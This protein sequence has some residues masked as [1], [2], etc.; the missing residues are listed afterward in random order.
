MVLFLFQDLS[1]IPIQC[2]DILNKDWDLRDMKNSTSC[3]KL[4]NSELQMD[5][6]YSITNIKMFLGPKYILGLIHFIF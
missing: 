6:I 2:P 1:V 5:K 4:L 3:N